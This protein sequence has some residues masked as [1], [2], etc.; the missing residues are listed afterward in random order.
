VLT[1]ST[2][3]CGARIIAIVYEVLCL[4]MRNPGT[5]TQVA[6]LGKFILVCT[7][8]VTIMALM[9]FILVSYITLK[10]LM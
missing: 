8:C 5:I 3:K 1:A 6:N 9:S 4:A 10:H 7:N 2:H